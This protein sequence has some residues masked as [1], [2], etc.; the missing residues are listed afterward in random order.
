M[1]RSN[2]PKK[3]A[4]EH[5]DR[6]LGVV[7]AHVGEAEPGRHLA[8]SWIVPSCHERPSTSVTWRSIFGP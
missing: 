1:K 3:R 5:E 8:S 7:L 4:V 6:V 2:E